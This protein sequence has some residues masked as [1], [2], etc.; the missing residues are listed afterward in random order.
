MAG[1]GKAEKLSLL[2]TDVANQ[3]LRNNRFKST[4]THLFYGL[5]WLETN[6]LLKFILSI[7]V[8]QLQDSLNGAE[9]KEK[10]RTHKNFKANILV[11]PFQY[12][13]YM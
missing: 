13:Q 3:L 8:S 6:M 1:R 11:N 2:S 10:E 12:N 5:N 4:K 7:D 9:Y